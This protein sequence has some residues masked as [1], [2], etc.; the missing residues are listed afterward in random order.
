V[1]FWLRGKRVINEIR[2]PRGRL[3]VSPRIIFAGGKLKIKK[4]KCYL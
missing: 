4:P 2:R 1:C 3:P